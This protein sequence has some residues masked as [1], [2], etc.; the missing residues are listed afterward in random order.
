MVWKYNMFKKI[1]AKNK[2]GIVG[3]TVEILQILRKKHYLLHINI[4]FMGF[5][6]VSQFQ[7]NHFS[8]L[9]K[10]NYI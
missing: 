8:N 1:E 10:P 7:V 5:F 3:K 2:W 9:N 6:F 4:F